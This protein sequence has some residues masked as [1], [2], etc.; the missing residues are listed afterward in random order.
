MLRAIIGVD[1]VEHAESVLR[2]LCRLKIDPTAVELLHVVDA[3]LPLM[4]VGAFSGPELIGEYADALRTIG[5]ETLKRAKQAACEQ[6]VT[7]RATLVYGPPAMTLLDYATENRLDLIALHATL[8]GPLG[9]FVYGSVSRAV[10]I[11]AKQSVLVAKGDVP[12][13]G[14]L[15]AIL[16]VD[17]SDYCNRCVDKLLAWK[18]LGLGEVCVL[19]A[20]HIEGPMLDLM[21]KK[22]LKGN[23]TASEWLEGRIREKNEQIVDRFRAMGV[24]AEQRIQHGHPNDVIRSA[25]KDLKAELAVLGAHGHGFLERLVVGSTS[26]HQ[27]VAEPYSTLLI[28]V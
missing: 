6:K 24:K 26:L 2:L 22:A 8:R 15:R 11:G 21:P 19:N 13:D 25:M 4:P 16:A 1:T 23:Q 17:H 20:F 28:R 5:E 18:P 9:S 14:P 10:A 27:V 7:A 12:S 3:S